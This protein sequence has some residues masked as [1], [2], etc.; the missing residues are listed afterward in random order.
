MLTAKTDEFDRVMGLEMGADDYITKPFSLRELLARIKSVLR[1][2]QP[3]AESAMCCGVGNLSSTRKNLRVEA[4]LGD[5][6]DPCRIPVARDVSSAA[7]RGLQS[8]AIAAGHHG[9]RLSQL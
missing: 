3:Q 2:V 1:R 7:R 5:C 6:F 4:R 9:R 8:F